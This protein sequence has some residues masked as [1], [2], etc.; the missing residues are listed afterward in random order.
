M[1]GP[2]GCE[3]GCELDTLLG[4]MP[5]WPELQ[6]KDNRITCVLHNNN[7][8]F[9]LWNLQ[10]QV[11]L[12]VKLNALIYHNFKEPDNPTVYSFGHILHI[13]IFKLVYFISL[14]IHNP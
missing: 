2:L 9:E 10:L 13:Y 12:S 3:R 6:Y 5:C 4:C 14:S 8:R 11:T 1:N 7:T